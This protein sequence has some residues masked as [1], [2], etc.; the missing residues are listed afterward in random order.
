MDALLDSYYYDLNYDVSK[1]KWDDLKEQQEI[2]DKL[3]K[4]QDKAN[5]IIVLQSFLDR[6]AEHMTDIIKVTGVEHYW[7]S[8]ADLGIKLTNAKM[9]I[10]DL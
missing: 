5:E 9:E 6:H 8:F 7:R 1:L 2:I 10:A 4:Y 3:K